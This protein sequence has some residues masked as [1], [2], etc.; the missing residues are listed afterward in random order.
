MRDAPER[1]GSG[2]AEGQSKKESFNPTIVGGRPRGGHNLS[3]GIPRGIEVLIKK[4]AVDPEFRALLLDKRV[5]AATEIGLELS[6][7][8]ATMLAAI[9]CQQIQTIIENTAVPDEQR[10]AFL[11]QVAAVMLAALGAGLTGCVVQTPYGSTRDQLTSGLEGPITYGIRPDYGW[12]KTLLRSNPVASRVPRQFQVI[13]V[14]VEDQG[15]NAVTVLVSCRSAF[16]SAG[17]SIFLRSRNDWHQPLMY[18]KPYD[19][20]V[21]TGENEIRFH[22]QGIAGTTDWLIVRLVNKDR[23]EKAKPV[24]DEFFKYPLDESRVGEWAYSDHVIFRIVKY[25]RE[26][27]G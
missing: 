15:L 10:R 21:R 2:H 19:A 4:A 26:W 12:V 9:P 23:R 13:R 20:Y 3:R 8:E 5:Q 25:H 14:S 11:G 18:H 7:A 24:L 27:P 1:P 16:Y 6:A 22:V 17:L